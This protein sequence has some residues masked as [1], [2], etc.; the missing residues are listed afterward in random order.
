MEKRAVAGKKDR[1]VYSPFTKPALN[2]GN[3]GLQITMRITDARAAR[4]SA[5]TVFPRPIPAFTLPRPS[6]P[7][8]RAPVAMLMALP[9]EATAL[10]GAGLDRRRAL[11]RGRAVLDALDRLKLAVL[12]GGSAAVALAD[13]E[14]ESL[15][16]PASGDG[17]L[18]AILA[19]IHLRAEVELA[20][21][22]AAKQRAGG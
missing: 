18:D 3:Q 16:A 20:K 17:A 1:A 19:A 13:L 12:A 22:Q 11:R 15:A 21:V 2:D 7:P 10:A 6:T 14:A 9:V 4:Q 5:S 8:L